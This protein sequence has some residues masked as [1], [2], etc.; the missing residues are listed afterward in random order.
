[1]ADVASTTPVGAGGAHLFTCLACHVAFHSAEHQRQHYRTDWHRYN[2]KR[3]VAQ[4]APVT[5]E[6]FAEKLMAQRAQ[7]DEEQAQASFTGECRICGK[8]FA[9]E[10]AYTQH[11]QSK[12][13]K[14]TERRLTQ[15]GEDVQQ[16]DEQPVA[17]D[18]D[19]MIDETASPDQ[20]LQAINERIEN[21]PRLAEGDCL[22]CTHQSESLEGNVEHMVKQHSFFIPDIDYLV[23]LRG[24]ISYLAD[25]ITVG[26]ICLYCNGRGRGLRSVEAVRRHMIDKGH[27]KIAYDSERD[28]L[29]ISDFYDFR[30]SYPDHEARA[31][32][33]EDVEAEDEEMAPR[34][35]ESGVAIDDGHE[36]VLPS[37]MRVGHRSLRRYYKQYI[38]PEDERES[39]VINRLLT[40]HG[41]QGLQRAQAE[42]RAL[43]LMSEFQKRQ[44]LSHQESRRRNDFKTRVGVKANKLQRYFREQV[45]Y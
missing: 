31:A 34:G 43:Q 36:L 40:Q 11:I 7:A 30:T 6:Q 27:T 18:K 15:D 17:M 38:R 19:G 32:D 33:G 42:C 20:V 35:Q 8:R 41:H 22:F 14:E 39:V 28:V 45:L 9:S 29:E 16:P 10:N 1:M 2:L 13:H 25:K 3:K 23:N 44:V 12:K 37:G 26:N 21:A 5:A 4:L 24:L